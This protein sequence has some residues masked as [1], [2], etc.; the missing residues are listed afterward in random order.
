MA[1]SVQSISPEIQLVIDEISSFPD[2]HQLV[3]VLV[4]EKNVL[5]KTE[6]S[7]QLPN[8]NQHQGVS[9]TGVKKIEQVYWWIPADYPLRSP[10]PSLRL[11]FPKNLPHINPYTPGKHVSPCISDMP[12][13][14]LLH[15]SGLAAILTAMAQW[16]NHAAAD[17]LHCP[18][19]GWEHV[20]RDNAKGMVVVDTHAIREDLDTKNTPVRFYRYKY[21]SGKELNGQILGNL[22]TPSLGSANESYKRKFAFV[23]RASTIQHA[24]GILFQTAPD[25]VLGE[26]R[27]EMVSDLQSLRSFSDYL[28]LK[29]AFEARIRYVLSITSPEAM[30]KNDKVEIEEFLVIFAIKRPFKLI[31]VD[32]CWELLPYRVS[33]AMNDYNSL[34]DTIQVRP[35]HFVERAGPQLLQSV[36][37]RKMD[38]PIRIGALGCGSLGSKT[39]LHLAKSG[40]Y[41]FELVDSDIFNSH[42]N[43]RHGLIVPDFDVL[44][45]SKTQLL[46]RELGQLNIVSKPIDKD[47]CTLG[48]KNGYTLKKSTDYII[49]STA[50]LQVRLQVRHFLAHQCQHL[51]GK[52]IHAVMYGKAAIGMIA[53]EGINRTIRVDDLMA[54]ANTLCIDSVII[55][56]AMYGNDGPKLHHYGEGCSSITTTMSDIDISLMSVAI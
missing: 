19:Q 17:E 54:Y 10:M 52:L 2:V 25:K 39:V 32:S 50:S 40:S 43:A 45:H 24:P 4:G 41:E 29:D 23:T 47:I 51:P 1:E 56:A 49:D 26:Y 3:D 30:H 44:S 28:G 36:S 22:I 8:A 27:P 5:V 31:G 9:R 15:T 37:G 21:L 33:Y 20:R 12:L 11:D 18:V 46:S 42:N 48:Q 6:W 13:N 35:V 7:V 53:H 55:Q 16:L 34:S 38:A 14:D